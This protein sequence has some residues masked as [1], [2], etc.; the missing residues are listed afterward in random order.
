MASRKNT[1]ESNII[2]RSHL[3]RRIFSLFF[4]FLVKV[5]IYVKSLYY[6]IVFV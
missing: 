6:I 2:L 1:L 3:E 4:V 5:K